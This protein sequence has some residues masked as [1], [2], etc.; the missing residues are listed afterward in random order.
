MHSFAHPA[1]WALLG[2]I[3]ASALGAIV[4]C[5]LVLASLS[6]DQPDGR[7]RRL[8]LTR[9]AQALSTACFG[10][11]AMLAVVAL[12]RTSP[13]NAPGREARAARAEVERKHQAILLD[14]LLELLQRRAGLRDG[15]A[16]GGV[17]LFDA[18]HALHRQHDFVRIRQRAAHQPGHAAL[19]RNGD[20]F[21]MTEPQQRG[22]ILRRSRADDCAR[23]RHRI[24]GEIVMIARVDV[25]A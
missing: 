25:A 7:K 13:D 11:V 4:M 23:F 10:M 16:G 19:R 22:D 14:P 15:D 8:L 18:V 6:A 20:T 5:L 9:L 3:V 2:I 12:S 1:P 21:A 24:A 17:D